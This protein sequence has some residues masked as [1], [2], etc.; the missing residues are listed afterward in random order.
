MALI[1]YDW[2]NEG[3]HQ[4]FNDA[5]KNKFNKVLNKDNHDGYGRCGT[6]EI[7]SS[8]DQFLIAKK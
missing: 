1:N 5:R 2:I 7:R 6:K 3:F 8:M 4:G